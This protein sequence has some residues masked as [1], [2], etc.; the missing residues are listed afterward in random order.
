MFSL[1]YTFKTETV[2]LYTKKEIDLK[3]SDVML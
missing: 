2:E 3:L 1:T